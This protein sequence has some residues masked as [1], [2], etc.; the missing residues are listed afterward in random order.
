MQVVEVTWIDAAYNGSC[1]DFKEMQ[2]N[3][4]LVNLKTVGYLVEERTDCYVLCLEENI[5][6][7]TYRHICALPKSGIQSVKFLTSGG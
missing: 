2:N 1:W 3:F 5:G 4:G 6:E 7:K